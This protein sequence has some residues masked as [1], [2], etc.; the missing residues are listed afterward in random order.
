MKKK[1]KKQIAIGAGATLGVAVAAVAT[2]FLTGRRGR[3]T[4]RVLRGWTTRARREALSA[5]QKLKTVNQISYN[6]AIDQAFHRYRRFKDTNVT[7]VNALVR[8]LKG[9]W[10]RVKREVQK[11]TAIKRSEARRRKK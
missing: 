5:V 4:R 10:S 11:A 1:V 7:E 3:E 8:E 2:Y 9:H 6:R